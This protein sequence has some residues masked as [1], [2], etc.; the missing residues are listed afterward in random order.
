MVFTNAQL[1]TIHHALTKGAVC[2]DDHLVQGV[3]VYV[4]SMVISHGIERFDYLE[5]SQLQNPCAYI[6]MRSLQPINFFNDCDE[7]DVERVCRDQNFKPITLQVCY[8]VYYPNADPEPEW[9]TYARYERAQV[10]EAINTMLSLL[11][12]QQFTSCRRCQCYLPTG[13]MTN[14]K[15]RYCCV[16]QRRHREVNHR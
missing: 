14:G 7:P 10:I 6:R 13:F 15:C 11:C 9:Q 8:P 16:D 3:L 1:T 2:L 12:D 4:E 5:L